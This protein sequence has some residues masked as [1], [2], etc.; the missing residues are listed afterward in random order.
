MAARSW[1]RVPPFARAAALALATLVAAAVSLRP[2]AAQPATGSI[3]LTGVRLI[4]GT[5]RPAVDNATLVIANGR[6]E[7]VGGAALKPPAGAIV[8]NLSGKTVV[9]GLINAHG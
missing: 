3:V 7:A 9:P 6:V 5:G 4:D 1:N 8:I 2:S